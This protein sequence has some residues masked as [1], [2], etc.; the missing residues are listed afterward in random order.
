MR[1]LRVVVRASV[2]VAAIALGSCASNA[3]ATLPSG[4]IGEKAQPGVLVGGIYAG[5]PNDPS[6]CWA[7]QDVTVRVRK[8]NAAEDFALKIY[9]PD[10]AAFRAVDQG[11]VAT[12]DDRY[13][14]ERCCFGPGLHTVLFRL[15][16]L[17]RTRIGAVGVH[18]HARRSFV[19]AQAGY[20]ADKRR[21]AFVFMSAKFTTLFSG[22]F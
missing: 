15:P 11:I 21:L 20:N 17:L 4:I 18:L 3:R 22:R 7:D 2:V 16:P 12:F 10:L 6:C 14:V 1:C 9:I 8:T 5:V 19:P 13:R